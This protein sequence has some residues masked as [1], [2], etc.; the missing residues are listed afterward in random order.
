MSGK[1]KQFIGVFMK[2]MKLLKLV[3]NNFQFFFNQ[4]SQIF[5]TKTNY[6][7]KFFV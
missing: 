6:I 2:A 1:L 3:E 7:F 4:Y 5:T